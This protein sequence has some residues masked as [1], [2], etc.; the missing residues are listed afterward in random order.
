ML[1][2]E[3][4]ALKSQLAQNITTKYLASNNRFSAELMM[5][6]LR[7][8]DTVNQEDINMDIQ[9]IQ[10]SPNEPTKEKSNQVL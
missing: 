1:E 3:C 2:V 6:N 10:P 7:V 4:N 8:E 9:E 5:G